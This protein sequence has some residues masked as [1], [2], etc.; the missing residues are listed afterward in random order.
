VV[1]FNI[2]GGDLLS[3][4]NL[5]YDFSRTTDDT[6]THFNTPSALTLFVDLG[7]PLVT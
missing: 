3:A 4:E 1:A 5:G 6:P 7:I 2:R